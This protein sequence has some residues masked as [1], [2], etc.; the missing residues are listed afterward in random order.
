LPILF[1]FYLIYKIIKKPDA[2]LYGILKNNKMTLNDSSFFNS[3]IKIIF[4]GD[5]TV[6]KTSIISAIRHK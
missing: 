6:G 2:L 4:L 5:P 1:S 3:K